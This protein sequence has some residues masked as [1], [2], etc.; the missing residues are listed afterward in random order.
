MTWRWAYLAPTM[1]CV[2]LTLMA[3]NHGD[4]GFGQKSARHMV[5][6]NQSEAAYAAGGEQTAQN[7]LAS[8]TFDWTNHSGFK[9]IIGFTQTTNFSN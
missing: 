4:D 5:W 3:F 7:H 9:S 6:S 1:A 2:L 8:V